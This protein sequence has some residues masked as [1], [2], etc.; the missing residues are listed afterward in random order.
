L[1]T[2]HDWS[3]YDLDEPFPAIDVE[4]FTEGF[5]GFVESLIR[6][7]KGKTLREAL[8]EQETTSLK[9]IGT[10]EQVADKMQ[11]A[12]EEIG[13]DGFLM[14]GRPLTRRYYDEILDGL[15]PIL[16]KRGLTRTAYKHQ[17]LRDNL[18]EF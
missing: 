13:G 6:I 12:I 2:G 4:T 14:H 1:H 3:K 9:L 15:V 5:R 7:G 16:Q 18:M 17:L 10:P 11:A 8:S